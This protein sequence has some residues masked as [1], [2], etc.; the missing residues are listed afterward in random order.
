MIAHVNQN[1]LNS[2]YF[3][4]LNYALSERDTLLEHFLDNILDVQDPPIFEKLLHI[5][6][7]NKY[8]LK[9]IFLAIFT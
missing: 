1:T 5:M 3:L 7:R 9:D 2:L 8:L 6:S 4:Q